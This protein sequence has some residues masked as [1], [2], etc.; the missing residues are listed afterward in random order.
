MTNADWMAYW[1]KIKSTISGNITPA[2]LRKDNLG[3][4]MVIGLA[5]QDQTGDLSRERDNFK[6]LVA[7]SLTALQVLWPDGS[8]ILKCVGANTRATADLITLLSRH[9]KKISM[10]QPL[11][12]DPSSDK[13]YLVG[14]SFEKSP[15]VDNTVNLLREV[16]EKQR[17]GHSIA[18]LLVLPSPDT[19]LSIKRYNDLFV[20][21]RALVMKIVK[22]VILLI[23]SDQKQQAQQLLDTRVPRFD[24]YKT[25]I[26]WN[27]LS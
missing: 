9:F 16:H 6:L 26:Y 10:V 3:V 2:K 13:F 7:Q 5:Y 1:I 19:D 4:D 12:M 17:K 25:S 15:A 24:L 11:T 18:K 14:Q 8:L 23:E 21:R 27:L 22:D 20:Q